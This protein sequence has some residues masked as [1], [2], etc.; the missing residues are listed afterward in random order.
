MAGGFLHAAER[1]TVKTILDSTLEKA[2]TQ[3]PREVF[4]SLISTVEKFGGS[5]RSATIEQVKAALSDKDSKWSRYLTRMIRN[6]NKEVLSAFLM[7]AAYEGFYSGGKTA[8]ELEEQFGVDMPR[9]LIAEPEGLSYQ[10]LDRLAAQAEDLGI[11]IFLFVGREPLSKKEDILK[12][13]GSHSESAFHAFSSG[14]TV[15]E[16]FCR[17]LLRVRN[18]LV[19]VEPSA[20]KAMD[21]MSRAGLPFGASVLYNGDNVEEMT[22]DGFLDYLIS[23]GCF[24]AWYMRD[25][26]WLSPAENGTPLNA[27]QRQYVDGRLRQIRGSYSEKDILAVDLLGLGE[28]YKGARTGGRGFCHVDGTGDV[29]LFGLSHKSGANIK[30]KT[31]KD[32]ILMCYNSIEGI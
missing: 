1:K 19:S 22:S 8:R 9:V 10:Q 27:E 11:H 20:I 30:E 17:E 28:L 25:L 31:L 18:L 24:F 14:L 32:C 21:L 29:G 12:L 23:R 6:S 13:A 26:P 4:A 15:D 16:A 5:G 2:R 7:N 3:E